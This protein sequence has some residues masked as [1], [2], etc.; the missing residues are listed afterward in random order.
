[1]SLLKPPV[2]VVQGGTG[3][4]DAATARSN[5][6][7]TDIATQTVTQYDVLVGGAANAITSIGPGS[8]GQVFQSG[9]AAANPAYSTST[10][11]T[12][13]TGTGTLLRA[14]GT[15]WAATTATYPNIA[16]GTGTIMRAD[17]TNW[18]ASTATYPNTATGTGTVL[19][20]D[21]TNWVAS[22]A[23]YPNTATATGT[24]LRADGTNWSATTATYPT[25]TTA[26]QILYSSATNTIS[27][28][29]TAN[30]SVVLT[31]GSGVPSL[32][33]SLSNDFT[34]TSAT[35]GVTRAL[36]V[37]NT[38]NTNSASIAKVVAST[39][40]ASAGDAFYQA[41]TTATTWS[42]GCDNSDSDAYVL[43]QN[44]ALGT[45]NVMRVAT[46][47][48]VTFPLQ[49]AFLAYNSSTRSDATG[50]GTLVS[51]V[52]FDSEVFDQNSDFASNTFTAPVTGKYH[53]SA[54]VL[55]QQATAAM[56]ITG[57][58]ITSNRTY[59]L[60]NSSVAVVGNNTIIMSVLADMDANDTAT[61]SLLLSGGAK[62]VD[63]YG[64]GTTYRTVFSGYLVC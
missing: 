2:E 4:T 44:A 38:D 23:T 57:Q 48:E 15:N 16:T 47:G 49:S 62:V 12:T 58:I 27:E 46:T 6:G 45:T 39:G 64:D 33:T 34:Y 42:W 18:V 3:A 32:G 56:P 11:P 20:A 13:A 26:N 14:D 7:I 25:T 43:S 53:L 37:S 9:G 17:G 61:V 22:T 55:I 50:D 28:I 1:M 31:D 36:T 35:A 10:Y 54:T 5:L 51:P 63:I 19:R 60:Y 59:T 29:T 52:V 30:N 41:T 24:I 8:A 21:G 40:G